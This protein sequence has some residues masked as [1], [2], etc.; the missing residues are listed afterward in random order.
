MEFLQ[1]EEWTNFL[2]D[3]IKTAPWWISIFI[4]W[5]SST[6]EY[7]F[8]PFPGDTI[9]LA[10]GF[11]AARGA[12]SFWAV[13]AGTFLGSLSG[14]LICWKV[15]AMCNTR[16]KWHAWLAKQFGQNNLD[17][18]HDLIRNHGR[19][20]LVVNRF[21]PGIRSVFTFATGLGEMPLKLVLFWGSVASILWNLFVMALG[22][23]FGENLEDVIDFF[24]S[25]TQI[26]VGLMV[27]LAALWFGRYLWK[28]ES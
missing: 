11:F 13:F 1:I 7:V 5:F 17:K 24:T 10:G 22:Y 16:P 25:Y 23:A 28:K 14:I 6:I 18:V 27:L 26:M 3:L 4:L 12:I 2:V 15:G 19:G 21:V 9:M 20:I 8:P